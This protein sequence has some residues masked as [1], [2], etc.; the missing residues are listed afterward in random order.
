MTL[1]VAVATVAVTVV[2]AAAGCALTTNARRCSNKSLA[3]FPDAASMRTLSEGGE[4]KL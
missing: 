1:A 4:R 3:K 2:V